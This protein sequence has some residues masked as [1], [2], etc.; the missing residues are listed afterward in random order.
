MLY[1]IRGRSRLQGVAGFVQSD[2]QGDFMKRFMFCFLLAVLTLGAG[3]TA[4][5]GETG[6]YS[7]G[8][9]L[10]ENGSLPPRPGFYTKSYLVHYY[11][12]TLRDARGDKVGDTFELSSTMLVNRLIHVTGVKILGADWAVHGII[13]VQY[14]DLT[15]PLGQSDSDGGVGD[16][17]IEPLLLGWHGEQWDLLFGTGVYL[18]TGSWDR[19]EVVNV[20]KDFYT[21]MVSLGGSWH[22]DK[23]R[24]WHAGAR[25]RYETHTA[26]RTLDIRHGDDFTLEF[27]AGKIFMNR[28]DIGIGGYA[29][30]QVEDDKGTDVH[31]DRGVHDRVW[32]LGPEI[33]LLLPE[34]NGT[35]G[36][37]YIREFAAV[38]RTEGH[39]FGASLLVAW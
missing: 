13:P 3:E 36:F 34:I 27:S 39:L 29:Q 15:N 31:W 37:S 26:N 7:P 10:F 20:G 25:V 21:F 2:F 22:F 11:S 24:T 19:D 18:P 23:A 12:D 30:W 38:D 8:V 4:Y 1:R 35:L 28:F 14:T 5:P 32:G 9:D 17:M 16:I 6:H 33:R